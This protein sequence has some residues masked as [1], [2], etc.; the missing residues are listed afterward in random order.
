MLVSGR[1]VDLSRLGLGRCGRLASKRV[2][3]WLECCGQEKGRKEKKRK[4]R[5]R[6]HGGWI[7]RTCVFTPKKTNMSPEDQW[8][9]DVFPIKIVPFRGTC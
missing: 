4:K 7:M 2:F 5:R 8:L 9:E 1:V 3:S 6:S